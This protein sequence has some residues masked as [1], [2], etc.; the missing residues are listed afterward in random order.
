MSKHPEQI[1]EENQVTQQKKLGHSKI[2]I[3]DNKALSENL[4]TPKVMH[5]IENINS[6]VHI[7]KRI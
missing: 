5:N 7:S 4:K 3:N 6:L 2:I 1:L